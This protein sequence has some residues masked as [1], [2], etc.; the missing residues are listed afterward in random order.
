[1]DRLETA[2]RLGQILSKLHTAVFNLRNGDMS[3][4][5]L[6]KLMEEKLTEAIKVL[7]EK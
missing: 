6:K 1:M 2:Y 5:E 7:E 3:K 4:K